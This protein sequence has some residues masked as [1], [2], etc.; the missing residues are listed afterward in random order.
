MWGPSAV[1]RVHGWNAFRAASMLFASAALASCSGMPSTPQSAIQPLP[2]TPGGGR[3]S[4]TSVAR[5]AVRPALIGGYLSVYLQNSLA[6]PIKVFVASKQFAPFFSL[7][8]ESPCL[9]LRQQWSTKNYFVST[10]IPITARIIVRYWPEQPP[11]PVN[12]GRGVCEVQRRGQKSRSG[13]VNV[14][15]KFTNDVAALNPSFSV[16]CETVHE[17]EY[18]TQYVSVDGRAGS[19]DMDQ[20]CSGYECCYT[21]EFP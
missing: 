4:E 19:F 16:S 18:C 5:H 12:A 6:Y 9:Q 20:R 21:C 2:Q 8:S 11:G 14:V 13:A 15:P 1:G 3:A 7:D 10:T 17:E